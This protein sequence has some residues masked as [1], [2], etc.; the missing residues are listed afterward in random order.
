MC[1]TKKS[2]G[3]NSDPADSV[4]GSTKYLASSKQTEVTRHSSQGGSIAYSMA[5]TKDNFLLLDIPDKPHSHPIHRTAEQ[6]GRPERRLLSQERQLRK[7]VIVH[8]ARA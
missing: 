4:M 2:K 8:I 1:S 7:I 6:A 3:T 5:Y